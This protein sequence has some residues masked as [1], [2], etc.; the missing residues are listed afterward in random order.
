[1]PLPSTLPTAPTEGPPLPAWLLSAPPVAVAAWSLAQGLQP[2]EH[3]SQADVLAEIPAA[4]GGVRGGLRPEVS[5]TLKAAGLDCKVYHHEDGTAEVR[6]VRPPW[7]APAPCPRC[8]R[9]PG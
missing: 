3:R 8:R 1:M 2:G 5:S 4:G 9:G 6:W 7:R